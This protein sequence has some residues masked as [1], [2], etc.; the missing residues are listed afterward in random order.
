MKK[1]TDSPA[2]L[3]ATSDLLKALELKGLSTDHEPSSDEWARMMADDEIQEAIREVGRRCDEEGVPIN[4]N[5]I[6][7]LKRE[8]D[9]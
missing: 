6:E 3:K 7:T 8:N 5:V 2:I 9:S 1:L 4:E